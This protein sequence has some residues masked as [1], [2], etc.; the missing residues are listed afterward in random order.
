MNAY[1]AVGIC[2]LIGTEH[3]FGRGNDARP[4]DPVCRPDRRECAPRCSRATITLGESDCWPGLRLR[5]ECAG[6]SQRRGRRA[7]QLRSGGMIWNVRSKG[8][9]AGPP[10]I[11]AS[12]D[13]AQ[14]RSPARDH[15][16]VSSSCLSPFL[17]GRSGGRGGQCWQHG[18]TTGGAPLAP[19]RVPWPATRPGPGRPGGPGEPSDPSRSQAPW[20]L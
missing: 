16:H 3:P 5:G 7:G 2:E 18:P 12:M 13:S 9:V 11:S 19:A 6:R 8:P 17:S 1:K 14:Q 15:L 10:A 20:P 4:G